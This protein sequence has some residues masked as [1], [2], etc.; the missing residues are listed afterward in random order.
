V[1]VSGCLY[2]VRKSAYAPIP[3]DLISDFVIALRI[4]ERGLRTVL[5]PAAIC[6]EQTHDSA[7]NELPMRVRVAIRSINALVQERRLLNVLRFGVFAWQLW[8]HKLLRYA[9]PLLWIAA[10]AANAVLIDWAPYRVSI[11]AQLIVLLAGAAGFFVQGSGLSLGILR[12]PYYFVLTNAASLIALI[13]Y[14]RGERMVTW[15]PIR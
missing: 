8:S 14:L 13:R 10:L 6:F 4:R 15:K 3:A 9:S 5:E 2:A 11:A 7:R 1:G 12:R